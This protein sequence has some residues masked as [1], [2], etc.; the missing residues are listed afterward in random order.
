[1]MC[2]LLAIMLNLTVIVQ[3]MKSNQRTSSYIRAIQDGTTELYWSNRKEW[4]SRHGI[5]NG[6]RCS[7]KTCQNTD[8]T[9]CNY[10]SRRLRR[11][12]RVK[13]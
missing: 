9:K 11:N 4:N 13:R 8:C 2:Y 12:D 5:R 7:G 6:A 1:M 10:S 3:D